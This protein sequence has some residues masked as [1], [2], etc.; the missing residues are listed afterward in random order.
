MLGVGKMS[1][2]EH[3]DELR[4][5]IVRSC[6]AV[7][8]GILVT[9]AYIN[10]IF[11]FILAPTRKALPP[12]VKLIY[13]QPG[14]A[15]SLY[16]TVA[17]I[18][19]AVVAA[20]YIMYQV[21]MFIAPGLY[22]N[23]K[24]MAIPFVLFTT[25]GFVAGALFN[26]YISFPFMMAFFASFNTPDLAFMPKLEDVFG[27]YTKMLI[28]MGLVFQMPTIVYFLARIKLITARFLA[29]NFKYAFLII[30]IV[31]A[32]ITPTGDMMTQAIFA[33]PMVGLYLLSIAIAW[34]VGPNRIG[35]AD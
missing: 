1:F 18:A 23:E 4:K 28:G 25:I 29:K 3:L 24:R 27:L 14:E 33:A 19:G 17:L 7:A 22:S 30:F 26:H 20:P 2:L 9:F 34:I 32:V 16:I 8:V 35:D 11:N 15:F 31:A 12:G 6:L 10:P 5:R 13:T 21:W